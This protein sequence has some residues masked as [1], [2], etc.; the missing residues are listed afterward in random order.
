MWSTLMAQVLSR[1][2]NKK[3]TLFEEIFQTNSKKVIT[4]VTVVQVKFTSPV[5]ASSL[6]IILNSL[7]AKAILDPSHSFSL[8]AKVVPTVLVQDVVRYIASDVQPKDKLV[9]NVTVLAI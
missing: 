3:P 2:S 8:K 9:A 5:K 7:H 6:Q 1:A 4:Q